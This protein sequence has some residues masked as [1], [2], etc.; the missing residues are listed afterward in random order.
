MKKIL[1]LVLT[2][3]MLLPLVGCGNTDQPDDPSV[4]TEQ[5]TSGVSDSWMGADLNGVAG[6]V[7]GGWY[8][9]FAA[10]TELVMEKEPMI[11]FKVSPGSGIGNSATIGEGTFDMGWVYPPMAQLAYEGQTPYEEK[12]ENIRMVATGLSPQVIEVVARASVDVDSID[13]IFKNH[14]G[15]RW[16]TPNKGSTT[17]ALFFDIMLQYYNTT[18]SDIKSWGGSTTYTPYSDWAQFVQDG[19]ADIMF[20]QGSMPFSTTQEIAAN[21]SLKLLSL[22]EGLRNYM[23]EKYALQEYTIAG[24]TYDFEDQ[25][26]NTLQMCSG[27]GCNAELDDDTVYRIIEIIEANLDE[28]K[29]ISASFSNFDLATAWQNTG[30]VPLHPGAERFYREHGY[31]T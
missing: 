12:Y 7:G 6:A 30:S 22:P 17:P 16:L 10:F 21:T 8:S 4:N 1:A 26:I 23:V 5:Q 27:L 15:I 13:D 2:V 25:D 20:N 19:H 18:E 9:T 28:F 14:V 24:G 31:M 29:S 11:S 3:V